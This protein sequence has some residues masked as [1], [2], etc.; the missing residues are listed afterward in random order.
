MDHKALFITP[1]APFDQFLRGDA[2]AFTAPEKE[3]LQLFISKGFA[4]CHGGVNVGGSG[5]KQY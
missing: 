5:L 4:T 1:N 2:K 3:G